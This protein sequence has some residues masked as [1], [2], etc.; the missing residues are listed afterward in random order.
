MGELNSK[1]TISQASL[2]KLVQVRLLSFGQLFYSFLTANIK[3]FRT[4]I[5]VLCVIAAQ[6]IG[7]GQASA[8]YLPDTGITWCVDDDSTI[9]CPEEGQEFYGQDASYQF[10]QPAYEDT[11]Y[12]TIVDRRT[13]LEWQ[14]L[15]SDVKNWQDAKFYCDGLSLGIHSDWRLPELYELETIVDY[16]REDPAYDTDYF[17]F[18]SEEG[19]AITWTATESSSPDYV[20][21][22]FHEDGFPEDV[23]KNSPAFLPGIPY[24]PHARCVRGGSGDG[25]GPYDEWAE[26]IFDAGTGL[27]WQK[28]SSPTTYTWNDALEYCESL[29][30]KS[31]TDWRLPNIRELNSIVDRH[32]RNPAI[33]LGFDNTSS[34][35]YWSS[36]PYGWFR[37]WAI[38]FL[39]GTFENYKYTNDHKYAYSNSVRCVRGLSGNPRI[40]VTFTGG[41]QGEVIIKSVDNPRHGISCEKTCTSDNSDFEPGERVR[42]TAK[43]NSNSLFKGWFGPF[44]SGKDACTVTLDDPVLVEAEFVKRASENKAYLPA[45]HFLLRELFGN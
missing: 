16:N 32:N 11:V 26:T 4:V 5:A 8:F 31:H 27:T 1:I 28:D 42:L 9:A 30:L 35:E 29:D 18:L 21:V 19:R 41:G 34:S 22:I 39:D 38:D 33:D 45:V 14:R 24:L 36:T 10:D 17:H 20:W 2:S 6:L 25:P 7:L 23:S 13:G 37:A 40:T 43:P 3:E 15:D 44:C 12:S